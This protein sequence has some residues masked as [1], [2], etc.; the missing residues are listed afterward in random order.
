[1][2]STYSVGS[3]NSTNSFFSVNSEG[4]I[5]SIGC[6]PDK[7]GAAT[8][9]QGDGSVHPIPRGPHGQSAHLSYTYF[10]ICGSPTDPSFPGEGA[11]DYLADNKFWAPYLN[12]SQISSTRTTRTTAQRQGSLLGDAQHAVVERRGHVQLAGHHV[13]RAARRHARDWHQAR[14]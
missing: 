9:T 6:T 5:F 7:M 13:R 11:K 3:W 1:M 10:R 12:P 8:Y 4:T 2:H 14:T